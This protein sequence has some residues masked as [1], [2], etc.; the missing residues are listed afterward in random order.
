VQ[1]NGSRIQ[2]KTDG[3]PAAEI[4]PDGELIVA[5]TTVAMDERSRALARDYREGILAVA[6]AGMDLGVQGADLGMKAAGDAIASIFRGDTEQVEERI[7]AEARK[8]EAAAMQ[9]CDS[10]PQLLQA[11]QALAAAVPEFAPYAHMDA[12]D[13]EDCHTSIES[14][15]DDDAPTAP[16]DPAA[17]ADAAATVVGARRA[18]RGRRT[19]HAP[20]TIHA[21][22][23]SKP[24]APRRRTAHVPLRHPR[25]AAP[26]HRVRARAGGRMRAQRVAQSRPRLR[27]REVGAVRGRSPQAAR[28]SRLGGQ[29]QGRGPRLRVGPRP[30]GAPDPRPGA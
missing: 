16:A 12:G 23:A 8:L 28:R 19:G 27:R 7:E 22:A 10:L 14:G 1:V 18:P 4:T 25:P 15:T 21:I 3:L 29:Q 9:L 6:S 2:R 30:P 26:R 5:G 20:S 13:I 11:Q 17:E 24:H